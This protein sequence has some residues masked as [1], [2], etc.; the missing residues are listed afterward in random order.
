MENISMKGICLTKV[1]TTELGIREGR[2]WFLDTI[3]TGRK[4]VSLNKIVKMALLAEA[5]N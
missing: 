5:G 4:E 1:K 3:V 2:T